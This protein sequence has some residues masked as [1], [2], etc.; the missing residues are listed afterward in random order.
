MLW[1][2]MC[3]CLSRAS[4]QSFSVKL[5]NS[6]V[7]SQATAPSDPL[8]EQ[9]FFKPL[10][11]AAAQPDA[12]PPLDPALFSDPATFGTVVGSGP[13]AGPDDFVAPSED[14]APATDLLND[15]LGPPPIFSTFVLGG[16]PAQPGRFP[17]IVSLRRPSGSHYCGG[18]L[19]APNKVLTAAHCVTPGRP[20]N[21][22]ASPTA[23]VGGVNTNI[24]SEYK[25][26]NT[27]SIKNHPGWRGRVDMGFDLAIITLDRDLWK[28]TV[29]V[30]SQ[31]T[32]I[33]DRQ[34]LVVAGWG[35]SGPRQR[36]SEVLKIGK[37]Q[38]MSRRECGQ[39]Y[40][41]A[42]GM[43]F[44]G[45]SML[46]AFSRTTDAC[47]GDS[48]GPLIIPDPQNR[49]S[50]D[51]VVGVVSLGVGG[52][53]IDG[54]PAI[55][56]NAMHMSR[57]VGSDARKAAWSAL[58]KQKVPASPSPVVRSP[59]PQPKPP[60]VQQRGIVSPPP[61]SGCHSKY[62]V[63]WQIA[64]CPYGVQTWYD[65]VQSQFL[66]TL[67]QGTGISPSSVKTGV[68]WGFSPL[69][70]CFCALHTR[71]T[72]VLETYKMSEAFALAEFVRDRSNVLKRLAD[73]TAR[74]NC[75]ETLQISTGYA[76]FPCFP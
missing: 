38:A 72:A 24:K 20:N 2:T 41:E 66:S 1:A 6:P 19:I 55:Y 47:Q 32:Q 34:D 56:G 4:S 33:P 65:T 57:F 5:D 58:V 46:C 64:L 36:I 26:A 48:G 23:W 37:V 9:S 27:L 35:F 18:A 68:D 43:N 53:R 63:K 60:V 69:Q 51:V 12:A 54:T 14:D 13:W 45:P 49:P 21:G 74:V 17:Y 73:R 8:L 16:K 52:C 50:H 40:R 61:T 30:A 44:I 71:V 10:D 7:G 15:F 76:G 67:A 29:A 39:R 42:I 22:E 70:S 3:W 25:V 31:E 59:P 62:E 28:G 11:P 75:A